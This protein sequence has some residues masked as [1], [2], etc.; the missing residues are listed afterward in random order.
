MFS[1]NAFTFGLSMFE[2]AHHLYQMSWVIT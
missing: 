1:Q 2:V